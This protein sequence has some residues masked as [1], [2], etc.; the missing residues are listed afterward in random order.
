MILL[1]VVWVLVAIVLSL[2]IA[3]VFGAASRADAESRK[4]QAEQATRTA[5][6]RPSDFRPDSKEPRTASGSK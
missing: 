6:E 2:V 4:R 5:T 3:R 1:F